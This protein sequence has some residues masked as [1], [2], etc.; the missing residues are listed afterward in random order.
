MDIPQISQKYDQD[1]TSRFEAIFKQS[2]R[3]NGFS[4]S[5]IN[6]AQPYID[7]AKKGVIK[8]NPNSNTLSPEQ[9][10]VAQAID[11]KVKQTNS[12]NE[13]KAKAKIRKNTAAQKS[14]AK[15]QATK[16]KVESHQ[17]FN[18]EVPL[19]WP[20][21]VFSEPKFTSPVDLEDA[22]S[23][24]KEDYPESQ[25][26]VDKLKNWFK[27][28][29]KKKKAELV[30][31]SGTHIKADK[32]GNITMHVVGSMKH[33]IEGDYALEVK[34]SHDLI[35]NGSRYVKVGEEGEVN[36]IGDSKV[37]VGGTLKE[38]ASEIHHN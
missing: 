24:M 21:P 12:L 36:I 10:Q 37:K 22:N 16:S 29:H 25:G 5:E 11:Y 7:K 28:N 8:S 33:I 18:S 6:K 32:E 14:Q 2:L 20:E 35:I 9:K 27:F 15:K 4:S 23:S 38:N 13:T 30:L 34:G 31:N 19:T 1:F 3:N 26:M 17:V